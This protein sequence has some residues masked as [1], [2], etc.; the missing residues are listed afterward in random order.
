MATRAFA[1]CGIFAM[2]RNYPFPEALGSASAKP[3]GLE[4]QNSLLVVMLIFGA[5]NAPV[6]AQ[7]A[8]PV[9]E[10]GRSTGLMQSVREFRHKAGQAAL[11]HRR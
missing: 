8:N 5:L 10:A 7:I 2:A 4:I 1:L 9:L 11:L 6:S 3:G